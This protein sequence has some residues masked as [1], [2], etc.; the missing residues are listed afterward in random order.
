MPEND[1][2]QICFTLERETADWIESQA[3]ENHRSVSGQ[4]AYVL[5]QAKKN[6]KK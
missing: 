2:K 3:K 1:N 4:V 6:H 5:M